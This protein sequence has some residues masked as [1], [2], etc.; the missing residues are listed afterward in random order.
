MYG[1]AKTASKL[2]EDTGARPEDNGNWFS[3]GAA[4]SRALKSAERCCCWYLIVCCCQEGFTRGWVPSTARSWMSHSH[5]V[6]MVTL[7][8]ASYKKA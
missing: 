2:T 4:S 1:S 3:W 6:C 7:T 5:S 8:E